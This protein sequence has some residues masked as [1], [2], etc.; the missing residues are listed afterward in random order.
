MTNKQKT[1]LITA[2]VILISIVIITL[3]IKNRTQISYPTKQTSVDEKQ[4]VP[5]EDKKYNGPQAE[6][7]SKI[8]FSQEAKK[9]LTDEV[10]GKIVGISPTFLIV[11]QPAGAFTVELDLNKIPVF[12]GDEKK[13]A[14]ALDLKTGVTVVVSVDKSTGIPTEVVIQ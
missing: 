6:P 3:I 5:Q 1:I 10:K 8:V 13:K 2:V 12:K 9:P 11:D 7:N 14:S 4:T